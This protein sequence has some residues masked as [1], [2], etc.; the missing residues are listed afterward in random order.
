[1]FVG[2]AESRRYVL[3]GVGV[4]EDR[5]GAGK[6]V[7]TLD[8]YPCCYMLLPPPPPA[9]IL[10]L[11]PHLRRHRQVP[12]HAAGLHRHLAARLRQ[13]LITRLGLC[14]YVCVCVWGGGYIHD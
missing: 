4:G 5:G 10:Q 7:W 11:L 8:G 3:R 12:Q 1:M 6:G 14:V 13:G 9:S 2:F